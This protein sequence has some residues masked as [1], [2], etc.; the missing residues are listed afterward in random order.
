MYCGKCGAE[1]DNNARFCK[2]CGQP[3]NPE[4]SKPAKM[5]FSSKA[6]N[7]AQS[8]QATDPSLSGASQPSGKKKTPMPKNMV[9]GIVAVVLVLIVIVCVSVN[10]RNTI[11]LNKYLT[12]ETTGYDGYGSAN[13]SIDW[14]AIE[15]KYGSR[16]KLKSV[17]KDEYGGLTGLI[18]PMDVVQYSISVQLDP[19]TD[20]SN[21]DKISYTWDVNDDI[22][23]AINCKLKYKDGDYTVS[24]L[25]KVGT[26]D[27]FA[28]LEV[29]FSGVAPNGVADLN[30]TGSELNYY[31]FS[32]DKTSELSNG[33]TVTVTISDSVVDGC[34]ARLG[35]VPETLEKEYTVDGLD[36]YV[37][38]LDEID[39]ETLEQMQAHA[40]DVF[41]AQI[42]QSWSDGAE[43]SSLSYIGD[44]LLTSKTANNWNA[45]NYLILVYKAQIHT[46]FSGQDASYDQMNDDYWYICFDNLMLGADGKLQVDI[47]DYSTPGNRFTIDSGVRDGWFTKRWDFYGYATLDDLYNSAVVRNIDAYN[48]EDNVSDEAAPQSIVRNRKGDETGTAESEAAGDSSA[49]AE[50]ETTA[51][52]V[53]ETESGAETAASTDVEVTES[54]STD[55]GYIFPNSDTQLLTKDQLAGF[56]A[57]KC[58]LARNE[59]Y[60]RHGRTFKDENIQNYFDACDWY[61]GTI[62]P[63]K[64]KDSDLSPVEIANRDLI[65]NYEQE[66]GYR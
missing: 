24:G 30:Y 29:A 2:N 54:V 6:T 64:F 47:T 66:N 50:S 23:D 61:H 59:I 18:S 45:Q 49:V 46:A 37:M 33:D 60:A 12:I 34:A 7:S 52:S 31:D 32:C 44:Y 20:L 21:G 42:A 25:E 11:D 51:E 55:N 4:Q 48:H 26:F 53:A 17:D 43:L 28:D 8:G 19:S 9:I 57:W 35:K 36:S 58:K 65:V 41:H 14:D 5:A 39:A 62:A 38:K 1:N 56:S 15:E 10:A 40:T 16:L 13:V 22:A 27:A 3:L 63:S